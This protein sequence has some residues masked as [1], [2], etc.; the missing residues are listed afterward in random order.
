MSSALEN[1]CGPG[2]PLKAEPPDAAEFAGLLRSAQARLMDAARAELALDSRFDLAY[3][4]AHG[5]CV[6]V[7]RR[8]GYRATQRYIVFQL[9]PHTLGLGPEVWRVLSRCH[10]LRNLA[11]YE[12]E[13]QVTE[14]LLEELIGICRRLVERVGGS[15]KWP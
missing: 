12:G 15:A 7:L 4:A 9:L 14:E 2:K 1:L 10:D 11:E 6:A 3:G 8:C 13:L 5:L